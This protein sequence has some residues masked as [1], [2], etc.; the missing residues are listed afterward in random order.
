MAPF[1]KSWIFFLY[2]LSIMMFARPLIHPHPLTS[3]VQPPS[4]TLDPSSC[5]SRSIILSASSTS[6]SLLISSRPL[7]RHSLR[8]ALFNFF[9]L[10]VTVTFL[11]YSKTIIHPTAFDF[12]AAFSNV[13]SLRFRYHQLKAWGVWYY[14]IQDRSVQIFCIR[15]SS[16]IYKWSVKRHSFSFS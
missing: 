11:W 3:S 10:L 1:W 16:G 4:F 12:R 15:I 13:Y 9:T 7:P 6:S 5:L 2:I 8:L 14:N